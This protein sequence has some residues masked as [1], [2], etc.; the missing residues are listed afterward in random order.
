MVVP[1]V[2]A[3]RDHVPS[4]GVGEAPV[5]VSTATDVPDGVVACRSAAIQT[6][7]PAST[8]LAVKDPRSRS[9]TT[10]PT[11]SIQACMDASVD[12][13]RAS[14]SEK[15]RRYESAGRNAAIPLRST[16]KVR[17]PVLTGDSD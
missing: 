17:V 12:P 3:Q 14:A 9:G 6:A 11:L 7:P 16:Y 15:E 2:G 13:V 1:F 10:T 8:G 4:S 5:R